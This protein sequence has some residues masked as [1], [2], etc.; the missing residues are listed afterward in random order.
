[1]NY[2]IGDPIDPA[3]RDYPASY[4]KRA[5]EILQKRRGKVIVEIGSMRIPVNH[6]IEEDYHKC[7]CDG[8]STMLFAL[9]R[10]DVYSVDIDPNAVNNTD[11]MLKKNG[12]RA[13]LLCADGI[14]F[15][16]NFGERIDLLFMDAWDVDLSDSCEKHL[17]AYRAARPNLHADSLILIDDTDVEL[18][19]K[20]ILFG[21]GRAGK[22]KLVIPAAEADGWTV[23][24][25]GRQ[26]LLIW[27]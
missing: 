24:F 16:R 23:A 10:N 7:C 14:E 18:T 1:M 11:A 13:F 4:I 12:L 2:S 22:G 27:R 25:D 20:G 9:T 6:P 8:H 26:T 3:K 5:L 19:D 15:L 17:E 21:D